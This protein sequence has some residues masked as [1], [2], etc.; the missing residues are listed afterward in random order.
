MQ[1]RVMCGEVHPERSG[2]CDK[3]RP[4]SGYHADSAA[5]VVWGYTPPPE[6]QPK[7]RRTRGASQKAALAEIAQRAE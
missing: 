3:P 1:R 4:C 7:Q 6:P 2:V 5:N